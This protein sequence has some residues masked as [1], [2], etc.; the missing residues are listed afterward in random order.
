[1]AILAMVKNDSE[2][3]LSNMPNF[4]KIATG[5]IDGKFRKVRIQ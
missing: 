2:V 1:M 3:M 5:Y 4:W